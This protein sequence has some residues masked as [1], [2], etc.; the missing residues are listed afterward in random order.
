MAF[1]NL[2]TRTVVGRFESYEVG[3]APLPIP[4]GRAKLFEVAGRPHLLYKEYGKERRGKREVDRLESLAEDGRKLFKEGA[5]PGD[6]H[7]IAWPRDFVLR[8]K[9]IV[10][11]V[12]VPRAEERF[13]LSRQGASLITRSLDHMRAGR[14]VMPAQGRLTVMRQL[15]EAFDF[16]HE[17]NLVHGDI[18]H[19]NVL[20]CPP[21]QPLALLIDCDGLRDPAQ[22][23]GRGT[24]YWRDPR[25]EAEEIDSPDMYSDWFV[26]ALAIWR[27]ATLH[28]GAP[29]REGEGIV[30][31][32]EFPL[33]L[34]ELLRRALDDDRDVEARPTPGEWA[35][36]LAAVGR[37]R[38]QCRELDVLAGLK[39]ADSPAPAT[40]R[41]SSGRAVPSDSS[42]LPL[43]L[44][45]SPEGEVSLP[46]TPPP[47]A[48]SRR[49][50]ILRPLSAA[51]VLALAGLLTVGWLSGTGQPG[52][53]E[54]AE[55]S[56]QRWARNNLGPGV[57]ASCPSTSTLHAGARYSCKVESHTGAV[58]RVWISIGAERGIR[59]HMGI[60]R[61]RKRAIVRALRTHYRRRA[62]RGAPGLIAIAC[63]E[64]LPARAGADMTCRCTFS[65]DSTEAVRVTLQSH[66]G[67][68]VWR[69]EAGSG[70]RG[71]ILRRHPA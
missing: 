45:V 25:E 5:S 59:R 69:G 12:V 7:H 27:K 15:A 20:W 18:S 30:L 32:P 22:K 1:V 28:N 8:G 6:T 4:I 29:A 34:G 14:E 58:A 24:K 38:S 13:F 19:N 36:A 55:R 60:Q 49:F 41:P 33:R 52:P 63:P 10:E 11:G 37:S 31:P 57:E 17:R 54:R 40:P 67:H 64:S 44:L 26:L 66:R 43:P 53:E 62:A 23:G 35:K 51:A 21:P 2:E 39:A 71:A 42:S 3:V 48:A 50:R 70:G 61:F 65:D 47:V 56:V 46:K 16:L 9:T 68:F